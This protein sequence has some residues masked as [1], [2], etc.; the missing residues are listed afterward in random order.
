[1]AGTARFATPHPHNK[2]EMLSRDQLIHLFNRFAFL[3]SQPDVKRRIADA[4]QDQQEAIAVTTAIQEEILVEM[5]VDPRLGIAFLGKVNVVYENDRDLLVKFY[6][7][8]AKEEMACDE[9][10]LKPEEFAEKMNMQQKLQEQQLEMLKTMRKYGP[11]DQSAILE[12]L[13]EQ[14]VNANFDQNASF[15]TNEQIKEIVQTRT[16]PFF[17]AG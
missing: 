7:F 14:M 11:D 12:M 16:S 17:R 8:A 2:A 1:M 5:G 3:T 4:V 9:A 15:L 13:H 6:E 10:E